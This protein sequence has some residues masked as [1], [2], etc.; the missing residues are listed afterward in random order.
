M[1]SHFA[2]YKPR[3][4]PSQNRRRLSHF[5]RSPRSTIEDCPLLPG[6]RRI[7]AGF[8]LV[9]L[10][11][12]IAIIGLLI[13]LLLPAVQSA[14]ES[15]RRMEC[16]AHLKQIGL[17]LLNHHDAP[18][19]FSIGLHRA[20]RRSH[21]LGQRRWRRGARLDL[22]VPNPAVCRR[23]FAQQ[24]VQSS[25]P[26]LGSC[27]RGTGDNGNSLVFMPFRERPFDDLYGQRWQRQ[28]I[29]HVRSCE[30]RGH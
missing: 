3:K 13:G 24:A 4:N 30:L 20:R 9:E 21:G 2:R 25:S 5:S 15:A 7:T 12:V 10:L 6:G 18:L 17:A 19:L 22:P 1:R 27:K 29:S 8:T 16:S 23:N 11:V 14:R 26:L 28:S